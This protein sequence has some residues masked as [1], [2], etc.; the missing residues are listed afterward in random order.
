MAHA[1][2]Y[3]AKRWVAWIREDDG[4]ASGCAENDINA[5]G[6]VRMAFVSANCDT[7]WLKAAWR[8]SSVMD[9]VAVTFAGAHVGGC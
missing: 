8:V 1:L 7:L 5:W 2:I 4:V 6:R 3:S 9:M